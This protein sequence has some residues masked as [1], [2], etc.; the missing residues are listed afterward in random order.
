VNGLPEIGRFLV[1]AGTIVIVVGVMFLL[2]DKIPLGRLPGDFRVG[3]LNIQVPVTTCV[4]VCVVLT[5]LFN[6]F[7]RK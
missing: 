4:L 6:L 7:A 1:V 2:A 3:A 5:V